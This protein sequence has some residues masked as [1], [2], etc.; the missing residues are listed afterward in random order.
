MVTV[1]ELRSD[2]QAIRELLVGLRSAVAASATPDVVEERLGILRQLL[3]QHLQREAEAW[4]PCAA[5]LQRVCWA[6]G[7]ADC[8]E[9]EVVLRDLEALAL[10]WRLHPT[11]TLALHMERLLDELRERLDEEEQ[12]FFPV[13]AAGEQGERVSTGLVKAW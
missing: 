10:A 11:Q 13:M 6:Q 7:L 9:P 3:H 5:Q 4:H 1:E 2:H 12:E 8:G